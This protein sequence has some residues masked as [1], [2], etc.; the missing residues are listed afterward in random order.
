MNIYHIPITVLHVGGGLLTQVPGIDRFRQYMVMTTFPRIPLEGAH[1]FNLW[2]FS[3]VYLSATF[4]KGPVENS[5]K[6]L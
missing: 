5:Q 2:N 6:S 1:L 4:I 3:S